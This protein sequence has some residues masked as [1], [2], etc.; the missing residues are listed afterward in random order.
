MCSH[1]S[2]QDG[3][4][5]QPLIAGEMLGRRPPGLT[6]ELREAS[7]MHA[8]PAGGVDADRP[9]MVQALDEAEHRGR[10]CR[11]GHLGL[12]NGRKKRSLAEG[13]GLRHF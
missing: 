2:D 6:G 1:P 8:M 13:V 10:L 9:D 11:L 12:T 7:L 5:A 3:V 4:A